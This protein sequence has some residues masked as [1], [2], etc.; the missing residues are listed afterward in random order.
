MRKKKTN[1]IGQVLLWVFIVGLMIGVYAKVNYDSIASNEALVEGIQ[2]ELRAMD[3][4]YRDRL[5][6]VVT[7]SDTDLI[8]D[9]V[10]RYNSNLSELA[11]TTISVS[12]T[13]LP[14]I[15]S[16]PNLNTVGT[17]TSGTISVGVGGTGTTTMLAYH[18]L[19]GDGSNG[20]TA[21]SST[22][23]SGQFL[24]SNG[25]GAYPSWTTSSIDQA[26]GYIWTG[27]H[28]FTISS[29]TNATSTYQG[30]DS[31]GHI[32]SAATATSTFA[33]GLNLTGGCLAISG[34]CVGSGNWELLGQVESAVST[35][36]VGIAGLPARQFLKVVMHSGGTNSTA[37]YYMRFNNDSAANYGYLRAENGGSGSGVGNTNQIELT[38]NSTTTPVLSNMFITNISDERKIVEY[39]SIMEGSGVEMITYIDGGGLW[40]N[41]SAQ[42]SQITVETDNTATKNFNSG[43]VLQVWGSN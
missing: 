27:N 30:I 16:L 13:T 1:L 23:T 18:V 31:S 43:F 14:L 38:A 26:A 8:S 37:S 2:S 15:T 5:G 32:Y 12:T 28:T 20:I 29:T 21:A 33:G 25:A 7:I 22:G 34:S 4:D 11:S 35:S 41:T 39:D 24:T 19:L 6:A 36:S 3:Q 10:S 17:I 9:F 42:I 40:N